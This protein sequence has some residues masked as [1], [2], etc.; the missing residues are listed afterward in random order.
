MLVGREAER[1]TIRNAIDAARAGR[2]GALVLRGEAGIGKTALLDDVVAHADAMT[3]VRTVG[4]ESETELEFSALLDVCRPLLEHLTELPRQQ[5]DALRAV[6]GLGP[7]VALDRFAT[8]AATLALLAAAAEVEPLLVVVDDAQWVDP[9]SADA[10]LFASRRLADD[11]VLVVF[12]VREGEERPFIAPGLASLRLEGLARDEAASLL[13][14]H[15]SVPPG[16]AARL[17]EATGGNPLAMIELPALLSADQLAGAA[18]LQEP[19]PVGPSVEQAF[20]GQ[21][22]ALPDDSRRAL[23]VAAVSGTGEVETVM[24]AL[25]A[26]RLDAAAL[27]PAEDAGLVSV[28]EGRLEFRHPLVRSAVYHAA[29]PSERRAAHRALADVL[30]G[31]ARAEARAWH[32]AAAALR[33]DED[34]AQALEEACDRSCSHAA[35]ALALE[36]A[37]RLTPDHEEAV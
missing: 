19:I 17:Y 1:A 31:P 8:G 5:A 28:L 33:A 30:V 12:A 6:L 14:R 26:L 34:A 36:R 13:A 25:D 35:R 16:V 4:V 2:G 11:R 20:A 23:L 15:A 9:E 29:P 18:P 27:E 3:V 10:L 22:A 24:A 37:A 32:L 21:A 7:A